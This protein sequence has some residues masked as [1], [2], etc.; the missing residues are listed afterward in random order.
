MSNDTP[1]PIESRIDVDDYYDLRYWSNRFNVARWRICEAVLEV[2][3]NAGAVEAFLQSGRRPRHEPRRL[4][5]VEQLPF[6][7]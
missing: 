7:R 6:R 4:F 2:G 1:G 3:D 5:L